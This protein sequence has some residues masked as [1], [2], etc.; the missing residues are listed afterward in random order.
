MPLLDGR[1]CG[2]GS[3]NYACYTDKAVEQVSDRALASSDPDEVAK[4][5]H[6]ADQAVMADAPWVPIATGKQPLYRSERVKGWVYYPFSNNG[7]ITN[8]WLDGA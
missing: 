2:E 5:W 8:V 1:Y 7:D 4:L 3:T 6:E